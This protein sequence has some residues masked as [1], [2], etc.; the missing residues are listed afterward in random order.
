MSI[1]QFL[2]GRDGNKLNYRSYG[3]YTNNLT[4]SHSPPLRDMITEKC[5]KHNKRLGS[6]PP[7]T[8]A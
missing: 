8:T 6:F 1:S 7:G 5:I 3:K 2:P 4:I